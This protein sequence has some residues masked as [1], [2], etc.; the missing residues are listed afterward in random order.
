MFEWLRRRENNNDGVHM[1]RLLRHLHD[2]TTSL[3]S[4]RVA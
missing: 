3:H 4:E 2:I 1:P